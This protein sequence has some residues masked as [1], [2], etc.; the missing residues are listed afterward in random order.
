MRK[1]Y[2]VEYLKKLGYSGIYQNIWSGFRLK[3]NDWILATI[4]KF[5]NEAPEMLDIRR[6]DIRGQVFVWTP[7]FK[8]TP[9]SSVQCFAVRDMTASE[10]VEADIRLAAQG[11]S[12]IRPAK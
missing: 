5:A 9:Y 6:D 3:N 1:K 11:I 8:W 12:V 7:D 10:L 2:T 4:A